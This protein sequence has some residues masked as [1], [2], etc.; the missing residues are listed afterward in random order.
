M[1]QDLPDWTAHL[2]LHPH[3]EGGWYLETYRH[4]ATTLANGGVRS[5]ATAI[6]FLLRPGESSV[7][8]RLPSDELWLHHRGGPLRLFLG[9]QGET[10]GTA[11]EQ[12]LGSDLAAGQRP[13]ILVPG[14]T[15]QAARPVDEAALVS[16]IVVPGF[17][18]ADFTVGGDAPA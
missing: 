14:G 13:Q 3:T 1:A 6:Y 4:A 9:G 7:W 2:N 18:F 17:D 11:E 10:P 8:H 12:L 5:L 15:W 16:C